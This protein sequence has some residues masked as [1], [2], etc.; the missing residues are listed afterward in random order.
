MKI[1]L[2][3]HKELGLVGH[4]ITCPRVSD[5]WRI[6]FL[7]NYNREVIYWKENDN[8]IQDLG[9]IGDTEENDFFS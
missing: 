2:V 7:D 3:R 8:Y 9:V 1:H 5:R 4:A 6:K